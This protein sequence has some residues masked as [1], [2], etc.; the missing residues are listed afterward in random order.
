[1]PCARNTMLIALLIGLAVLTTHA[2]IVGNPE[3][4]G[5][6]QTPPTEPEIVDDW[7][8][9]LDNEDWLMR[10]LATLELGELDPGI[11]LEMLERYLHRTDLSVEQRARLRLACLRRFALRPKGALGVSFGTIR[12]GAIQVQPIPASPDFPASMLL[13]DKDQIAMVG[14]RVIDG[15]FSL[16]VEILSREPGEILPV[17]VVRD[18]RVLHL[19]LP[20][21]SFDDLTGAV[22]MD[23][24]LLNNA[25]SLRWKRLGIVSQPQGS[26]GEG[27]NLDDW[28]NA[29]FPKDATPD[30]R[31]PDLHAPRGWVIGPDLPTTTNSNGWSRASIDVWA[32]PGIL[33]SDAAK[34]EQL[35][36][37]ERVQP[38][39]A[40]RLLL[41]QERE[42]VKEGLEAAEQADERDALISQ[43]NGL[44]RRLDTITR[45]IELT[46][47][48]ESP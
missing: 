29:A 18:E 13:K 14:D 45:E 32:D 9:Q 43:L 7:V 6:S 28:R 20:L 35:L 11:S 19:D 21:G 27:L 3:P 41:E 12:I 39:I 33:R 37:A 42:Q 1:M 38:L 30:A 48:I 47:P 16:R 26:I 40:L 34:R 24:E 17:T 10:D 2:Q 15:S 31:E 23:S 22:R 36:A 8:E 5:Q 4:E 44:T 25:L 46:R